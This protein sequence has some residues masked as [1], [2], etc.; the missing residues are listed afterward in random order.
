MNTQDTFDICKLPLHSR[1]H[2]GSYTIK[3]A[4]KM[5]L[6]TS[7]Q[8]SNYHVSGDWKLIWS[9]RV[10]LTI[11]LFYGD[12][13]VVAYPRGLICKFV[14]SIASLLV[15]FVIITWKM[16]CTCLCIASL[17]LIVGKRKIFGAR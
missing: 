12:F 10:P 3:Y 5:C 7:N 8:R 9:L 15:W 4:Y 13:F 14:E 6:S 17:L 2:N 16:K 1:T 11:K